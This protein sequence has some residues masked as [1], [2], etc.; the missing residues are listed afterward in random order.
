MTS[1]V[2]VT[3]ENQD[4]YLD[5]IAEI[6]NLSFPSPWSPNAFIQEIR[7]PFSRLW[8]LLVDKALVGYICFWM[9][10]SEIQL[11]N[12]AIHPKAR[13]RG[14]GGRL[15]TKM[16]ESDVSKDMHSIWLEVRVSNLTA[17]KLYESLGFEEVGRRPRYYKDTNEDA[18]V[19]SL[20]LSEKEMYRKASN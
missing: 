15:L 2:N 8:A 11:I 4:T 19:M 17:Q 20:F 14:F 16:I 10:E 3:E 7:N 18:I 6:E 12:I 9:L 5:G 1:I 13:G